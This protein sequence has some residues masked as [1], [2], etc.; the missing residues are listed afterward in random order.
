MTATNTSRAAANGR[1]RS[2]LA[3]LVAR[4]AAVVRAAHSASVPF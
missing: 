4:I 3:R 1:R 2:R